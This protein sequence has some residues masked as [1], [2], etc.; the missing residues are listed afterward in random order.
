MRNDPR[1]I[2]ESASNVFVSGV[3]QARGSRLERSRCTIF[4]NE[5]PDFFAIEMRTPCFEKRRDRFLSRG[6][7]ADAGQHAIDTKATRETPMRLVTPRGLEP[8]TKSLGNSCSILLSY[9][10][11]AP[12]KATIL[13]LLSQFETSVRRAILIACML[14]S[15]PLFGQ[16]KP[17]P[18][19]RFGLCNEFDIEGLPPE[20]PR[21][22]VVITIDVGT[23]QA[24]LF[25]DGQL[26]KRSK[27]ATGSEKSLIVGDDEWLFHTPRGHMKVLRKITDPIWRK[28]DWAYLENNEPVPPK[29][30]P[31]RNVK[32][33]LGKY[34]L[35]L[36][37]GIL[38]HGTDDAAS[39]GRKVSHG[40]IRLPNGML[41]SVYES[42]SVGT[43][44]FV[45]DSG[46]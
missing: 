13:A 15:S 12:R 35:D 37:E 33:K 27:A 23:N 1:G 17:C 29:D 31:R 7:Y 19:Y 21:Q 14:F 5:E 32:G 44:V 30:S 9:G 36:G 24:Y 28:P 20:A 40:C 34:A 25:K 6:G 8:P 42:A 46:E 2:T 10:V 38:I 4:V 22:G 39:I 16:Q 18:W 3:P 45:F 43:D 26:V 41:K 11:L